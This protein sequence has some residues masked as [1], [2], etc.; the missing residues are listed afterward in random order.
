MPNTSMFLTHNLPKVVFFDA[1]GTLFDLKSSVGEI[2]QQYA[3]RYGVRTDAELLNNAFIKSF[4]SAPPLGFL[5]TKSTEIVEL[6]FNWWQNVVKAT[7]SQLDLLEDF[8]DFTVFF[9]DV[10]TYFATEDPWYVFSDTI[11][12]LERLQVRGVELGVISN[13]DTRLITVLNSLNLEQF[14]TNITIS[15]VAGF[16]KPDQNIFRIALDKH[17]LVAEQ[18]WHIGD[19][20][21]EDYQGGKNVGIKSF[22]LNRGSHSLNIENQLPN[23]SSLG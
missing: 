6:E 3:A 13:F 20:L 23:L 16:A 12:C 15:S 19:S 14:F 22:L 2:Y 10:Y 11:P 1:M 8:S 5:N 4:K 7:F 9:A 18:A 21:V 17:Q